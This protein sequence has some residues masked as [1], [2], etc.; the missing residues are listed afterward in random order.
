MELATTRNAPFWKLVAS[1]FQGKLLIKRGAFSAGAALVRTAAENFE[2]SGWGVWYPELVGTLA[3]GL[4]GLGEI[5]EAMAMIRKGMARAE[6]DGERWYI[7]E[8]VRLNGELELAGGLGKSISA[9]EDCFVRSIEL[10]QEQQALSWELRAAT[11]L[12]RLR[13]AQKQPDE[14]RS[15]LSPVYHRFSEGFATA[16]LRTARTVIDSLAY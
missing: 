3:E 5:S 14:A 1:F 7:P 4:A 16:D 15:L 13:I 8:L 12:A 11:G 9:A 10:A 2:S 6:R